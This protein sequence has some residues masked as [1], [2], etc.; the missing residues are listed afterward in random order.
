MNCAE[1]GEPMVSVQLVSHEHTLMGHIGDHDPNKHAWT[2][3][4]QCGHRFVIK[5]RVRCPA[6]RACEW[7]ALDEVVR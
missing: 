3:E 5:G 1:C 4:P 6:R 2:F 7:C